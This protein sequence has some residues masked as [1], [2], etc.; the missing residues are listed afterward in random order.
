MQIVSTYM[1]DVVGPR[2]R[3]L[4]RRFA[5]SFGVTYCLF[6]IL[7]IAAASSKRHSVLGGSEA[8]SADSFFAGL[9]EVA[10]GVSKLR[11]QDFHRV[12]IKEGKTIW[13]VKASDAQYYSSEG[14]THLDNAALTLY[15]ADNTKVA[16]QAN[17]AKLHMGDG[18][19]SR[20]EL[21]GG[22]VVRWD[23]GLTVESEAALYE[24]AKGEITAP[25]HV[26]IFGD[27]YNVEGDV[28][29]VLVEDQRLT[30]AR[31][32]QSVFTAR[33]GEQSSSTPKSLLKFTKPTAKS[34][35]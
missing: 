6:L 1:P 29:R 10:A 2:F 8:A 31:N 19:L 20:A 33:A 23:S 28:L 22:V 14:I 7:S 4:T 24:L 35:K 21:L 16:L 32:V 13:E 30:L 11:L 12:A 3:R 9:P 27:G 5:A 25:D 18:G 34:N 15:Q 26:K 17:S